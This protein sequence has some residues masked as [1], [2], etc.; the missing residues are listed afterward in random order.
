MA[1]FENQYIP[2]PWQAKIHQG[3]WMHAAVVG[4][5]GS[6]KTKMCIEE[7]KALAWE[8]PGTTYLVGRQTIPSLKDTTWR[9]LMD[10]LPEGFISDYNKTERNITLINGSRFI[11]RPLED[12]KK[13][14]S[15]KISGFL[16]DEADENEQEIYDTLKTR[17]REMIRL[18]SGRYQIPR[19]RTMLSLNP[20]E[21]DHWIPRIFMNNPPKDH[22]LVFSSTLDNLENLPPGYVQQLKQTYS[23]DM[24]QRMIYGMFGKVHKGRPVYPQFKRGEYI[25][26]V[27]V[28]PK[29]T[30]F[31]GWDFGYNRPA[32]VWLQFING[33]ARIFAEKLGEKIYLED[34]IPVCREM[35]RNLFPDNHIFKDF[36]D[37]RGADESDKGVT[38]ISIL[39]DAGIY[40]VFRRTF[41]EEGLKAIKELLDTKGPD[42]YPRFIIHGRC[43]NLIEGFR[44]GYHR[45]DGE[46]KPEKDNYYDHMQDALRYALIHLVRRH[47]FNKSEQVFANQKV[48]VHPISGRRIEY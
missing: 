45:L 4:G 11:G 17:V 37:P 34:F 29:A 8:V 6:G 42:G 41:I 16:L 18:P 13:F 36:C 46:N 19:Y 26:P 39:N 44:G 10:S 7:L 5:K 15:L 32:C 9:E 25:Q 1:E 33:Q 43:K 2:L 47:R 24:Q 30:I 31:R 3:H 27:E 38:S 21:E 14:D 48:F 40:P 22:I 28:D 12:P 20:T 23:E 35:E